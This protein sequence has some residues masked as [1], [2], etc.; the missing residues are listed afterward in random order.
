MD[1]TKSA[2]IM[3]TK[4]ITE[5]N[6]LLEIFNQILFSIPDTDTT[7]VFILL[8]NKINSNCRA[9]INLIEQGFINEGFMIF[10]SAI[11]TVIYAKYLKLYPKEQEKFLHLSDLFAI[12]NLFIKYKKI[13]NDQSAKTY[14]LL[15]LQ[16]SLEN[17]IRE[18]LNVSEFL[19][20]DFPISTLDFSEASFQKLDNYFKKQKFPSQRVS[21]LLARI[22]ER[23][24]LFARTTF[25][26]HDIFYPYYDEN[27]SIIH[28]NSRFWNVRPELDAFFLHRISSHLI[29]ILVTTTDLIQ[30]EIPQNLYD[31]FNQAVHKLTKLEFIYAPK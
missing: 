12:K 13:R 10:R 5:W 24:P 27:S 28:G 18:L 22:Q 26:L 15:I 11:E 3:Q 9:A 6:N 31:T 14:E 7:R 4:F 21:F 20:K 23:E 1:Y 8:T 2:T 16:K 29:R 17:Q 30:Y 19:K 25:D